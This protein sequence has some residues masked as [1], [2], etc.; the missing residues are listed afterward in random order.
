MFFLFQ[1]GFRGSF[2]A[3]A[4]APVRLPLP[5][6]GFLLADPFVGGDDAAVDAH[7]LPRPALERRPAR[8]HD[9]LRP[10]LLRLDLPLRHAPP[11]LRVAAAE[12]DG[13]RRP[14]ASRPTRRTPTSARSTTCSTRSSLAGVAGSAIGGLFDPICIA[15]RSIGLGVIPGVQYLSHRGLGA[16]QDVHSRP[17]QSRGRPHAGLARADRLAE[18]AVL[19]PPDLVHRLPARRGPLREPLH[20]ALLVPRAL[21]AGRVPRRLR[22]LRALRDDEGPREVH[23]LQ[24][25]PRALPGRRQPAGRRQVAAGRVPH[26]HELRER[27]PRGRDQVHVPARTGAAP[28][29]CPTPSGAR[30]WRPWARA[31]CSCRPRASPTRSTSTTSPR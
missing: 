20:P 9:G 1:T 13:P 22:A 30:R 25:V 15:V 21:P 8:A 31:R 11:L 16:A 29:R 10:R 14:R 4:D 27:V 28:S 23:R 5:V 3:R 2:A 6:E 19:L 7:G 24:P 26:V 12:Q 18:Q 17:I